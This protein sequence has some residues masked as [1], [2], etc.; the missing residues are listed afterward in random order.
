L[1]LV[2]QAEAQ[3]LRNKE[4]TVAALHFL[5]SLL[6]VVVGEVQMLFPVLQMD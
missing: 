2:A 1:V 5:Q 6:L 3:A 4:S